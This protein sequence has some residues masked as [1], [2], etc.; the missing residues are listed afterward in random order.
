MQRAI[1]SPLDPQKLAVD[2]KNEEE[3]LEVYFLS[4]L[5]IDVDHFMER[6]YLQALGD[7]LKIPQ[8]VRES[9]ETDIRA[10]KQKLPA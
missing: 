9:I 4:N 3:A 10:E 8:D 5:V 7:A 2:V 6:S 1:D